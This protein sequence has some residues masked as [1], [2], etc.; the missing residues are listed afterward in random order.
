MKPKQAVEAELRAKHEFFQ[1]LYFLRFLQNFVG[2]AL[3][4][5]R[6]L[7]TWGNGFRGERTERVDV[8]LGH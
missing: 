5:H 3:L 4:A 6:S 1:K 8:W 7:L 2:R